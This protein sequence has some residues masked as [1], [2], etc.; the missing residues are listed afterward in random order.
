MIYKIQD[1]TLNFGRIQTNPTQQKIAKVINFHSTLTEIPVLV[2][3]KV[4]NAFYW[5]Q[6][7][8]EP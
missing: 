4:K 1:G 3:L 5:T 8:C 2:F 6:I 7:V